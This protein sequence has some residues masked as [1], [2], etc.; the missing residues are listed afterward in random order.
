MINTDLIRLHLKAFGTISDTVSTGQ[1]TT[2]KDIQQDAATLGKD[3][4]SSKASDEPRT[5]RDTGD[6]KAHKFDCIAHLQILERQ[7]ESNAEKL[8]RRSL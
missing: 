7:T 2:H 8:R 6:E 4:T 3:D 1:D 5:A